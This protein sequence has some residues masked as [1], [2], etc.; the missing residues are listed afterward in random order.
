M[1]LLIGTLTIRYTTMM[2]QGS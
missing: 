1:N 2:L